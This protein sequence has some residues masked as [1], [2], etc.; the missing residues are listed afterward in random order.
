[1]II[2]TVNFQQHALENFE[3]LK[4]ALRRK[5]SAGYCEAVVSDML[6]VSNQ[7]LCDGSSE[8]VGYYFRTSFPVQNNGTKYSFRLP[9]DFGW[10]GVSILDGRI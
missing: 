3:L 9:T 6:S 2:K 10:G 5:P 7:A 8:F 1:M 4:D